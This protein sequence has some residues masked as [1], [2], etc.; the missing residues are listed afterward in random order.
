MNAIGNDIRKFERLFAALLSESGDSGGLAKLAL[1]V[2]W[3][4]PETVQVVAL[5]GKH[6]G[7]PKFP[8]GVVIGIQRDIVC[9]ILPNSELLPGALQVLAGRR[10][11]VGPVVMRREA[12]RSLMWTCRLLELTSGGS[13]GVVHVSD[14]LTELLVQQDDFL[15]RAMAA[16][17]L[18]PLSRLTQKQRR[19]MSET[20]LALLGS[21][22]ATAAARSLNIHVQ[23]LHYRKR[24]IEKL[25][26]SVLDQP[27]ARLEIVLALKG[28]KLLAERGDGID[29]GS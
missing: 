13:P 28:R 22:N 10:V 12:G 24:Q 21:D 29:S 5:T 16:R 25:F 14:Y 9:L 2:R 18:N 7:L 3:P 15:I 1:A 11:A 4:L 26:G 6:H 17:W 19:W 23:T 27:C 8:P 20:L